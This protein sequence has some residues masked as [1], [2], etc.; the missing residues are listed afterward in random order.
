VSERAAEIAVLSLGEAVSRLGSP[1]AL[2]SFATLTGEPALVVDLP[3]DGHTDVDDRA[4]ERALELLGQL[5]CPTIAIRGSALSP[6][7]TDWV[8]AFDVVVSSATDLDR[9]LGAIRKNPQAS[10]GLVQLLR[11]NAGVDVHQGLI[12]E[13][14]VYATL[15]GGEEF[16]AWRLGREV[17][18]VDA[19]DE[20]AAVLI[21]RR[22]AR[23]SLQLNRPSRH[24]AFSVELR[25]G[26]VEG[27]LLAADDDSIEEVVLTGRGRSFSS[28]GDLDE[29]GSFPDPPTAHLVRSTRNPGRLLSKMAERVHALVHGACIGAGVELPSFAGHVVAHEDAY[30]VL[31][32][33]GLGLVPGAGGTVSLLRRIGRQ[34]TAWMGLTGERIDASRALAWGLVDELREGSPEADPWSTLG[35]V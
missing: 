8:D 12:A 19:V 32:E 22:G 25:D 23:L 16:A 3:A 21:E 9:V 15:Q 11:H 33:L 28:G 13:S 2:E 17:K 26:V 4:V 7:A 27:L 10:L 14:L 31:P 35:G 5:A 6:L 18:A 20:G 34:R 30:F 1:Y 24:N 29:F